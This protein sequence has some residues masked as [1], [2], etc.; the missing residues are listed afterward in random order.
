MNTN[1]RSPETR[2]KTPTAGQHILAAISRGYPLFSG[3]AS[4]TN[5]SWF[6][7][8]SG[9]GHGRRA[10]ARVPGGVVNSALD[11]YVGRAC[12]YVGDLDPKL[13][14]VCKRLIGA[15]D[16]VV[17]IGANIGLMSV[18]FAKF[19]GAKGVVH[20]FEPNPLL[21]DVLVETFERNRA[22]SVRLHRMA[23]GEEPGVLEL[24]AP[25]DNAG[26]GS[27]VFHKNRADSRRYTVPV[28]TLSDVLGEAK[29]QKV[30]LIKIDFEGFEL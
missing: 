26:Q 6:T 15:G 7:S 11:D 19:V 30:R 18:L 4:I 23:L 2:V 10:W 24:C 20:A 27:L 1:A 22:T 5:S 12:F 16:T 29:T 14:W 28:R 3:G 9:S 13:T 8:W 17:D 21:Q 25:S